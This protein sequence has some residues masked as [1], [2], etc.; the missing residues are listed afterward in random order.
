[1]KKLL[2]FAILV[3]SS[4]AFARNCLAP[5]AP[6]SRCEV[7]VEGNTISECHLTSTSYTP[8]YPSNFPNRY[9]PGSYTYPWRRVAIGE[10]VSSC[11]VS[12][13]ECKDFAFRRLEKFSYVSNCGDLSY[14]KRVNFAYLSLNNDGSVGEEVTGSMRK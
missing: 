14:G 6:S 1:M 5:K 11:D 4:S 13:E 2:P 12:L 3:L 7:Q 10:E 8:N 9:N